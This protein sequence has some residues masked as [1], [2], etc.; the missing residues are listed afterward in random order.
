MD[1]GTLVLKQL[2][3][4]WSFLKNG[5]MGIYL[6]C[7]RNHAPSFA[8]SLMEENDAIP[9]LR[10]QIIKGSWQAPFFCIVI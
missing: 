3:I 1:G 2:D 9:I 5:Q 4:G 6:K 7:F 8:Q 10:Y